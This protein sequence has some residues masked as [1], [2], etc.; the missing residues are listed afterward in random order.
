MNKL[1]NQTLPNYNKMLESK[2]NIKSPPKKK[3]ERDIGVYKTPSKTEMRSAS[4]K[5]YISASKERAMA[6][7]VLSGNKQGT[8]IILNQCPENKEIAEEIKRLTGVINEKQKLIVGITKRLG[9][10]IGTLRNVRSLLDSLKESNEYV[11]DAER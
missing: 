8:E 2:E 7:K 6:S 10:F 5:A 4:R 9:E 11:E 1:D 3:L